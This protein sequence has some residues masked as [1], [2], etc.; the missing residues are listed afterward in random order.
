MSPDDVRALLAFLRARYDDDEQRAL[1]CIAEVGSDRVGDLFAD[2]SGV[3]DRDDY[4]SYPW[5][6]LA[7]ELA[8]A[9]GPGH[10]A[11]V[12]VKVAADRR[13]LDLHPIARDPG[14]P[15]Y[16][17][18]CRYTDDSDAAKPFGAA[19]YPCPTIRALA[20]PYVEHPDYRQE[21]Q[22]TATP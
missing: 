20:T 19:G 12:L 14:Q 13:I 6:S 18:T 21:W 5:G 16:C 1:D 3:A 9:A 15:P 4:P 10:P 17:E 8:F 22:P 7:A 11:R 2:G